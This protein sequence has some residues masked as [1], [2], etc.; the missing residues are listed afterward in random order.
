MSKACFAL[1]VLMIAGGM[2]VTATDF[3]SGESSAEILK[4]SDIVDGGMLLVLWADYMKRL[5]Q[6]RFPD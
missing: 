5:N 4:S 6:P 2:I 1:G 3:A